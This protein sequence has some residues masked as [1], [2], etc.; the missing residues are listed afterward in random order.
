MIDLHTHTYLSDGVLGP[1][2]H[3]RRA[4]ASG[5]RVLGISDHVDLSTLDR[6]IA[7]LLQA[8]REENELGG[9]P[10]VAAGV[11]LTYVRPA[12]IGRAAR[13]ARELGA[14]L[15]IVHGE[16]IVEPVPPGTN[17]AAIEADVDILAHP[18][19][20]S[21]EDALLAAKRNVL[22][23]ISGSRGHG[24][25]NGHVARMAERTGARLI[26]GSDCHAPG[27]Y[28]TRTDA[29]RVCRAAGIEPDAISGM[30][31]RAERLARHKSVQ[32]EMD[33]TPDW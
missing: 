11:E 27:Q 23:E 13:R 26:F 31:V 1:A 10:V 21:E 7:A 29:E 25:A 16:T 30:F 6:T 14:H 32:A 12:H 19:L 8:A 2:E 28:Y 20:L 3:I 4:E 33:Q 24:L 5:Y 22:L 9:G 17:R 15:V 18:G